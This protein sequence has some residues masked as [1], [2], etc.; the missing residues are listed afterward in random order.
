MANHLQPPPTGA[1]W[2]I[3]HPERRCNLSGLTPAFLRAGHAW[4]TSPGG[5]HLMWTSSSFI[6]H[7]SLDI[8]EHHHT[9]KSEPSHQPP[10][11]TDHSCLTWSRAIHP[12]P[13][14][15]PGPRLRGAD[16]QPSCFTLDYIL[17]FLLD[18]SSKWNCWNM[19]I[20]YPMQFLDD[21]GLDII[22]STVS[23]WNNSQMVLNVY[24]FMSDTR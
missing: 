18:W 4:N 11:A 24:P 8:S 1:Y 19:R 15:K 12:F 20:S 5:H 22:P 14:E 7:S 9:S 10:T 3:P 17:I 6:V 16:S 13:V 2:R 21:R 23:E